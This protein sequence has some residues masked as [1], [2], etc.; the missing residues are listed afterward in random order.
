M[1]AV[2]KPPR[3]VVLRLFVAGATASSEK[4]KTSL[5]AVCAELRAQRP[6]G[7]IQLE[8]IDVLT[9]P[10]TALLDQVFATPTVIRVSPGPARRLFGDLSSPEMVSI[11]LQLT[12][13]IVAA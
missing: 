11:G 2:S 6:G 13:D 7:D 3:R 10:D 5:N 12:P 8:T 9:D 1:N 4:A